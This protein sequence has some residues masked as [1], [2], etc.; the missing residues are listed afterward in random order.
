MLMEIFV[1]RQADI[2]EPLHRIG[3]F[4]D[5]DITARLG[6]KVV[7]ILEV[8]VPRTAIV[9]ADLPTLSRVPA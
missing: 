1:V 3:G 9:P 8:I 2:I 5:V 6:L 7:R 4:I